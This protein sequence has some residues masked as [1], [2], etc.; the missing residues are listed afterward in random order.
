MERKL[1]KPTDQRMALIKNQATDLLWYGKL[2]TTLERAKEISRYAE[3]LLTMAINTY[4]DEVVVTK[5]VENA[6]GEKIAQEFKN[7]GPKRLAA[8]RKLMSKLIDVQETKGEKESK[9]AY[10]ERTKDIHHPLIEKL[11]N[12]YAPK[13]A[14]KNKSQSQGGGYTRVLK[15]GKRRGDNAEM[16]IVELV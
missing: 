8:R 9:A 12:E 3:K 5:T 7:D 11:F 13:Y 15:L 10:R 4:S 14:E 16:A 2:E 1:G 6:K